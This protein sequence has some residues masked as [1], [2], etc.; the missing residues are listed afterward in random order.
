MRK[1]GK[2]FL[3]QRELLFDLLALGHARRLHRANL[4]DQPRLRPIQQHFV[5]VLATHEDVIDRLGC[6]LRRLRAGFLPLVERLH[7]LIV[8][9]LGLLVRLHCLR[10]GRVLRIAFGLVWRFRHV[11]DLVG[12]ARFELHDTIA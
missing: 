5:A 6:I 2:P 1:L 9:R 3:G 4:L 10:V 8:L 7:L 11:G 12:I